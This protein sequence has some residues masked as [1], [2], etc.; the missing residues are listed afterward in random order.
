MVNLTEAREE[1]ARQLWEEIEAIHAGMLG[2]EGSTLHMQPMA[3]YGDP[4]TN[5]IWFFTRTDSDFVQN[6]RPGS[7]AHFCVVGK[8]H[9]YHASLSGVIDV[10]RDPSKIDEY[11]SSVV[12]AWY[13]NGKKDPDL[14][15]LALHIDDAEVWASTGNPLKF[16]WEIAKANIDGEKLPD[17]GQHHHLTFA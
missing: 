12:E 10:R 3:P 1:P 6:I 14:T 4:K 11:W 16:G 9:D 15:M 17:V 2:L 8:N 7:R 13:H 5:T